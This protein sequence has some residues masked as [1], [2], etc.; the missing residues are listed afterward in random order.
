MSQTTNILIADDDETFLLSTADLLE[1]EGFTCAR[2]LD[3]RTATGLLQDG[4]YDL[5]IADIKMPG[6]ADLEFVGSLPELAPATPVIL[7]TG[8]PSLSTAIASVELRVVAYMVKPVDFHELLEWVREGIT[9]GR[10]LRAAGEAG[11]QL[12][13]WLHDV[14]EMADTLR[15]GPL[16]AGML[17]VDRFHKLTL[18]NVARSLTGLHDLTESVLAR[19]APPACNLLDCP[20][21]AA[22]IDAL[23]EAVAVL[24]KTRNSFKSKELGQLRRRMEEVLAEASRQRTS[25]SA[26][27][28]PGTRRRAGEPGRRGGR[29]A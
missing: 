14:Q 7:V 16:N 21:E 20:R 9:H 11:Q 13:D 6:N 4:S 8:Y 10:A 24:E 17:S 25:S 12:E 5:V 22:L 1:R 26:S 28:D 29:S 19:Q 2:A 23:R 18:G 27:P 15:A 3:G